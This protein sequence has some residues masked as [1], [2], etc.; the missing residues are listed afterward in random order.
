MGNNSNEVAIVIAQ[1]NSQIE[2]IVSWNMENNNE[3]TIIDAKQPYKVLWD[4]QGAMFVLEQDRLID[5]EKHC[6]IKAY[7]FQDLSKIDR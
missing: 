1:V 6:S 2:T 4:H 7:S 5:A 3:R